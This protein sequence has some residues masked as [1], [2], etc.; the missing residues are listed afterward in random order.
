MQVCDIIFGCGAS[1][2]EVKIRIV[3]YDYKCV[4]KLAGSLCIQ[5]EVGLKGHGNLN[6]LGNV[7]KRSARPNRTVKCVVSVICGREK[8]HKLLM[9][10]IRIFSLE[11]AFEVTVDYTLFLDFFLHIVVNKFGVI[12]CS[13]TCQGCT[14]CLR[15]S[16]T[17]KGIFNI[18]G[19]FFPGVLH[20]GI[21][22]DI[23]IDQVHVQS[24]NTWSPIGV[25]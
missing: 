13:D 12:L 21:G 24:F 10:Q 1:L 4:L 15:N 5:S 18:L 20:F 6:S 17:F 11:C 25:L 9:D 23:G 2:D 14:L 8:C 7:Y 22:T 16:K 19:N 3:F